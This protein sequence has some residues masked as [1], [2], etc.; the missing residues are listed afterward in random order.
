MDEQSAILG[1]NNHTKVSH[2]TTPNA[3]LTHTHTHT[4]T[5]NA[6]HTSTHALIQMHKGN[7]REIP[8]T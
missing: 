3:A 5:Q 4:F 2:H 7:K 1:H 8:L 6:T